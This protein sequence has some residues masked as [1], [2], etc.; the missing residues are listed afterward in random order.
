VVPSNG[1]NE[2]VT[3]HSLLAD[4]LGAVAPAR[5]SIASLSIAPAHLATL[6]RVE[7]ALI[8]DASPKRRIE[9][10]T[11][12][13]L[14]RAQFG[15]RAAILRAPNGAPRL[16]RGT[17]GSLAHDDTH[18][19]VATASA[20]DFVALGIDLEPVPQNADDLLEAELRDA[21]VRDNDAKVP[22]LANFVMK[23]AAYKAWSD[24]GG[25]LLDHLAVRLESD[26]HRFTAHFPPPGAVCHGVVV[27]VA[28]HWLALVAVPA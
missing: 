19:L 5:V 6:H 1:P 27:Y 15:T 3:S 26:G 11:G 2:R 13:A 23:E 20:A 22:P 17:V 9:F 8:A 14:L 28:D 21:V 12:R 24:L 18:V 16:Q 7:A 4:A 10:A 25:E